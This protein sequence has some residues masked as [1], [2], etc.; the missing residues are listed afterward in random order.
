MNWYLY[1]VEA[2]DLSLY[3][4]ITTNVKRRVMEHN[5]KKG[6]KALKGKIPVSL[7]YVER[8]NNR[9]EAS[10]REQEIKDM[11][12]AEK[13]KLIEEYTRV[14]SSTGRAVPS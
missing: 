12:R 14:R 10:K 6:A 4:G 8:Y 7:V 5:G 13:L 9:S 3:T 1:M 2:K 11:K